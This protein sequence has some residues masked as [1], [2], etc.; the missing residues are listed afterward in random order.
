MISQP[1]PPRNPY[2]PPAPAEAG[3]DP[4]A[5]R[6]RLRGLEVEV[7]HLISDV[8]DFKAETRTNTAELAE[9]RRLGMEAIAAVVPTIHREVGPLAY[10]LRLLEEGW[11]AP[12]KPH[13]WKIYAVLVMVLVSKA[14]RLMGVEIDILELVRLTLGSSVPR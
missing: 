1:N 11:L 10:R 3:S 12:L 5:M 7:S 6:E 8:Q 13:L 4:G 9:L 2:A 14:L